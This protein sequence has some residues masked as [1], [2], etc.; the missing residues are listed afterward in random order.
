M[1]AYVQYAKKLDARG[2]RGIFVGYDRESPAYLI[3]YP[4]VNKVERVRAFPKQ[5]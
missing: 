5:E 3:Y 1:F 4:E 2:K